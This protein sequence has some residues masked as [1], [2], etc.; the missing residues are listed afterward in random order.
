MIVSH[1][2]SSPQEVVQKQT[3]SQSPVLIIQAVILTP[4]NT[5]KQTNLNMKLSKPAAA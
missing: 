4:T 5:D 3:Y 1:T 2:L